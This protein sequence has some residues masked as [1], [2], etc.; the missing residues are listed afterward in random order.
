MGNNNLPRITRMGTDRK[1]LLIQ[2][3]DNLCDQREIKYSHRWHGWA[4]KFS[5][6]KLNKI[7]KHYLE[8][9]N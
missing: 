8:T 7:V 3:C 9:A 1:I 5:L 6:Q 2:I 4:R